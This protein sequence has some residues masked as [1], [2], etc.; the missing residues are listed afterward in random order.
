MTAQYQ[1][2]ATRRFHEATHVRFEIFCPNT[3]RVCVAG[4]FNGWKSH[5]TPLAPSGRGRW[6]RELWLPQGTHEYLFVVDGVWTF[7]PNATDYVPNVFG[8]MNAVINVAAPRK[9][10]RRVAAPARSSFA[11]SR[12]RNGKASPSRV[13]CF[14]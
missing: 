6:L 2:L 8:G 1:T 12:T 3:K 9:C 4:S 5:A 13:A 14:A 10:K 11:M 7:D